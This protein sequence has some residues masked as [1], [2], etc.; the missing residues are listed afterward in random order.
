MQHTSHSIRAGLNGRTNSFGALRLFFAAAVIFSHAF[1]LSGRGS[2]PTWEW[3]GSQV[4]IGNLAVYGFLGV[5]GYVVTKSAARLTPGRF[6]WHRVLRIYP[7]F[8]LALI[9]GAYVISPLIWGLSG[10]DMSA[11]WAE[12]NGPRSYL[13]RNAALWIQQWDIHDLFAPRPLGVV[14]SSPW[15]AGAVN[16]SLWSL[17]YEL[18]CYILIGAIAAFGILRHAK[19]VIAAVTGLFGILQLIVRFEPGVVGIYVGLLDDSLIT[20]GWVFMLGATAAVY[21]DRIPL[22]ARYGA[23]TIAVVVA[24]LWC[25]GFHV[26]GIPAF[27]YATIW[28][29]AALPHVFHRV[30]ARNDY[31]YGIYLYGW[32]VQ[33]VLAFAGLQHILIVYV[34]LS[35][36]GA[37]ALAWLSWHGV[38]KWAMRLKDIEPHRNKEVRSTSVLG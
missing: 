7:A 13:M 16:G 15:L 26:I 27:I 29:A 25:G 9:V 3:W 34:A 20:L 30:G 31:S 19:H 4:H 17:A 18:M 21:S 33:Q 28:A 23:L 35:V 12:P 6:A 10:R 2:D 22:R 37:T 8:W 5:S 32:P 1:P 36:L 38:E 14:P 11:F 24:T